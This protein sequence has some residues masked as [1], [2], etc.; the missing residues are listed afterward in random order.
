MT[1]D[2]GDAIKA[3]RNA[4]DALTSSQ[5]KRVKNYDTLVEAEKAYQ[6]ILDASKDLT[7]E[8]RKAADEVEKLIDAIDTTAP[9]AED[10]VKAAREAYD[11]LTEAQKELVKN[12][13]TLTK[14]EAELNMGKPD[15]D[16]KDRQDAPKTG[17][18]AQSILWTMAL[19][20]MGLTI[21]YLLKKKRE[22]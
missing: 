20:G 4:Y 22:F 16:D 14:A 9:G 18:A 17:D 11:A 8:D 21:G 7:D 2:S 6:A 1:A 15:P 12:R 3:A 5:Q 10:A 19:A 13:D